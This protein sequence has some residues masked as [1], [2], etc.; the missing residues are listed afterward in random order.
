M[1]ISERYMIGL[2]EQTKKGP[3]V[4]IKHGQHAKKELVFFLLI[5]VNA[6]DLIKILLK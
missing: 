4:R 2:E 3:S 6:L 1:T 5:K